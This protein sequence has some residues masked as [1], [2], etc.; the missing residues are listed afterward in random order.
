MNKTFKLIFGSAA[1]LAIAACSG[2]I[3]DSFFQVS[4]T[5]KGVVCIDGATISPNGQEAKD[6]VTHLKKY[7][8]GD[9]NVPSRVDSGA[10]FD[11]TCA[12]FKDK[13]TPDLIITIDQYKNIIIP[14]TPL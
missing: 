4:G 10:G 3:D 2:S 6:T 11:A 1:V 12:N 7:Y 5:G 8:G 9:L 14:A 13:P